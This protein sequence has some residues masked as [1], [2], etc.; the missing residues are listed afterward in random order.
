MKKKLL[1]AFLTLSLYSNGQNTI[2]VIG[3]QNAEEGQFPWIAD[4]HYNFLDI[5]IGHLC[6]GTLI[7]PQWVITA[8]HCVDFES[9]SPI[10]LSNLRFNTIN[11]NGSLNPSGGESR[12]ASEIY[13]H[14]EYFSNDVDLALIKLSSP[15]TTITPAQL[16]STINLGLYNI[17]NEILVAGWGL[18]SQSSN[19]SAATILQWVNSKI[20]TCTGNPGGIP[21]N[22]DI[23]FCIG[24]SEGETP[25]GAA[26]GD[27]GS[28]AFVFN[29]EN[30]M[31][32]G[33]VSHGELEYTDQD[34]PGRFV[35]V[36]NFL[37]WINSII[38]SLNLAENESNEFRIYSS[39]NNLIINA[40]LSSAKL[41]IFDLTGK[42]LL[43]QN[44]SFNNTN[45][46]M[47]ISFLQRGIYIAKITNS[48]GEI[49]TNKFIY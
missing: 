33:I 32:L 41:E 18:T 4:L 7:A 5:N 3:G 45:F 31:V 30:P 20:K 27:S 6:G 13:I 46:Q 23:Y 14:P 11:T 28:P 9:D 34:K 15:I 8:A 48:T 16:P 36:V 37:E 21:T 44:I 49:A 25:T 12:T 10:N 2:M 19:S 22:T 29:Q 26:S 47:D 38:N 35:K 42:S 24:Y 1:V 17:E 43:L 39:N 40:N